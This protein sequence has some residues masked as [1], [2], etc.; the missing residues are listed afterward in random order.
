MTLQEAINSGK[1]FRRPDFKPFKGKPTWLKKAYDE[2][3]RFAETNA[4]WS[5]RVED[6]TATDW[7]IEEK[8]IELTLNEIMNAINAASEARNHEQFK[9]MLAVNLGF[10]SYAVLPE[11]DDFHF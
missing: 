3:I 10:E 9:I 4:H 11:E 1:M 6:I 7:V 2:T 8:K 5:P